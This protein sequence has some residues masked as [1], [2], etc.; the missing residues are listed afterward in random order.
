MKYLFFDIECSN[1]FNGVGKLCEFG[2]VLCDENLNVL[3]KDDIPMSPGKG[4]GNKFHLRGR[5]NEKDF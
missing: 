4:E 2:Y 5:K 3:K 1:C